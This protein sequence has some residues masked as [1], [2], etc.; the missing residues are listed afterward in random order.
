MR[1]PITKPCVDQAEVDAVAEPLLSG[2]LAQGK[3][4]A[5][6]EQRIANY[7]E[8]QE[9]VACS[10]C[11]TGLHMALASLGL[12][13]GDEVIVPSFT[14]IATANAVELCGA[15]PVFCDINLE[16]FNIEVARV[17][18]TITPRT[19]A[20]V[21]VH[22]FGLPADLESL[23]G[24]ADQHR[25][26][27]VED[28][29]C[30]L[31]SRYHGRHVGTFGEVGVFSFHPRKV[32]TTGEGGMI[33]TADPHRAEVLRSLRNHG[34]GPM[35]ASVEPT[36]GQVGAGLMDDF[37]RLGFNYRMTDLQGAVG[38]AQMDKLGWILQRRS[39][40]AR[41]YDQLLADQP[42]LRSPCT[43][44]GMTH[45]FQSYVCLFGPTPVE[46]GRLDDLTRQRNTLLRILQ[47]KGI[48][49]RQGTHAVH[50]TA[51]YRGTHRLEPASL[52]GALTAD[53]LSVALPLFPQMTG[54]EQDYVVAQLARALES[55][56]GT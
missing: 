5:A 48:A 53:R 55:V 43:P 29:A 49:V 32:I 6:F 22:L 15:H 24:I 46:P 54:E 31:G 3:Q 33:V 28:A 39:E 13:Q 7:V 56:G 50:T 10:S 20:I 19:R 11:T 42:W 40:L 44:G 21:A 2:W 38:V 52:P 16:T 23:R 47:Q 26:A 35:A 14:W 36:A 12:Q 51:R 27:L 41:R 4:V 1:I 9:A 25:L 45:S 18:S 34:A 17:E 8:T 30:A 37:P